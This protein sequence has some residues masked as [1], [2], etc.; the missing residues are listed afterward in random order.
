MSR[1]DLYLNLILE[2]IEKIETSVN[3]KKKLK[4]DMNLQDA[5]LMRL[6]VIGENVKSIPL[7][8]K[9]KNNEIKWKKFERLR[10]LIIHRYASVNYDLIWSFIKT[11]LPELKKQIK[12]IKK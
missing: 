8:I 9:K 6:Q 10:N 2:M 7:R 4:E 3:S 5:T 1:Y 12:K 11:N